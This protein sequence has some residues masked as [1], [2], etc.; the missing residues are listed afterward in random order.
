MSK[1]YRGYDHRLIA[2]IADRV[3]AI[4]PN[5]GLTRALIDTR[6]LRALPEG[7]WPVQLPDREMPLEARALAASDPL[8][9]TFGG[10]GRTS[11][12]ID[13]ALGRPARASLAFRLDLGPIGGSGRCAVDGHVLDGCQGPGICALRPGAGGDTGIRKPTL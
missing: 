4:L 11:H 1:A 8:G 6:E 9:M 10:D 3:A 7:R 13:P 12:I 5:H 2:Y